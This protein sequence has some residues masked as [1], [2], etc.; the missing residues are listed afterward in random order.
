MTPPRV[1]ATPSALTLIEKLKEKHGPF[2]FQ[3]SEG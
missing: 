2:M 3:E 1:L